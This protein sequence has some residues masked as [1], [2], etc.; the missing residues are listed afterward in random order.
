MFYQY[1][2]PFVT[3]D[4]IL[5]DMKALPPQMTDEDKFYIGFFQEKKL[6]AVMDLVFHYPD[7][8]T[9][10]IGLFMVSKAQQ[11]KRAGSQIVDEC[12]RY[13]YSLGYRYVRLAFAKGN[14]QSEAFWKKNGFVKTGREFDN[15]DYTAVEMQKDL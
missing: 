2:P 13:I 9:A 5:E 3:K 8:H 11:G 15:G 1:C 10:Y 4:S 7:L 14:P 12:F 6:A